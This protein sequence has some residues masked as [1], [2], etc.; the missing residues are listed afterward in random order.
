MD[1][2]REGVVD[3]ITVIF[4]VSEVSGL[5][6]PRG[7]NG[8]FDAAVEVAVSNQLVSGLFKV[9]ILTIPTDRKREC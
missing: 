8:D 9:V 2:A 6:V 4:I 5:N 1:R 7:A 3:V